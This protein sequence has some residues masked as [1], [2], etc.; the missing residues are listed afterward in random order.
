[1]PRG[2]SCHR[3]SGRT[4]TLPVHAAVGNARRPQELPRLQVDGA[5]LVAAQID[6]V[7]VDA[8]QARR[9]G[10]RPLPEDLHPVGLD[11]IEPLRLRPLDEKRLAG[12]E[13]RAADGLGLLGHVVVEE[14]I[15]GLERVRLVAV[16]PVER[17]GFRV[18][19]GEHADVRVEIDRP[20]AVDQPRL[21]RRVRHVVVKVL[22]ALAKRA[23]LGLPEHFAVVGLDRQDELLRQA[24]PLLRIGLSLGRD[25]ELAVGQERQ[26]DQVERGVVGQV[27]RFPDDLAVVG[28]PA[29]QLKRGEEILVLQIAGQAPDVFAGGHDREPAGIEHAGQ[30]LLRQDFEIDETTPTARASCRS[31]RSTAKICP[32]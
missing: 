8:E 11:G 4:R 31:S 27:G 30:V 3:P 9:L 15:S 26:A 29:G 16:A 23:D 18:E 28:P 12:L 5:E 10:D 19:P 32:R 22:L 2:V 20:R 1:M 6:G 7:V 13:G 25:E 24:L 21:G 17:A 14:A